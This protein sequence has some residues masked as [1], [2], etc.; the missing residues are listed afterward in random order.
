MRRSARSV[1]QAEVT[2]GAKVLR[3]KLVRCIKDLSGMEYEKRGEAGEVGRNQ[4]A[5]VL[6][7]R[8]RIYLGFILRRMGN[9]WKVLRIRVS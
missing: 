4:V 7:A 1:V 6:W 8:V 9:Y 3:W 5:W 2:A